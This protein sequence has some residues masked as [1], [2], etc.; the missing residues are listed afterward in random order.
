MFQPS[1]ALLALEMEAECDW[2][3][4][5]W[6]AVGVV[7]WKSW[8]GWLG[9]VTPAVSPQVSELPFPFERHQQFEQSMRTPVGSTW[10]TQRAFQKLTA[11]RVITRTGHIIQPISAEDIPDTAPGSGAR[12]G[13][14]DMPQRTPVHRGKGG[15]AQPRGGK[16]GKAVPRGGKEGKAVPGGKGGKA[17]P[18]GGK[19][20]KA[21][22]KGKAQPRPHRVQ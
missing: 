18:R 11:P 22:P 7:G 16:E 21:V 4:D 10:N 20:G 3:L 8:A 19:G 14:E 5:E 13:A 9:A 12:L 2:V 17:Q 6:K 15:K 1:W